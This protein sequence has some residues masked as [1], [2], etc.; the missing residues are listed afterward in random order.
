MKNNK[1]SYHVALDFSLHRKETWEIIL[2]IRK[3]FNH[4]TFSEDKYGSS[5]FQGNS[6]LGKIPQL[7]FM[8]NFSVLVHLS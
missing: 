4:L 2:P 3:K 6:F 1:V 8:A 5:I 7:S